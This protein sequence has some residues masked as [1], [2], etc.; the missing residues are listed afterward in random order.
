MK[1][2][3]FST[4]ISLYF[5]NGKEIRPQLH[6]IRIGTRCDLSNG[7][8]V[9]LSIQNYFARVIYKTALDIINK[10]VLSK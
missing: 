7:A 9:G 4:N 1:H 2:W 6:G 3:R 8:I 10:K 5:E